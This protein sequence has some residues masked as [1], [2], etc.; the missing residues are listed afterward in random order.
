MPTIV[1]Q[2]VVESLEEALG[3]DDVRQILKRQISQERLDEL[4]K[5][6]TD[7]EKSNEI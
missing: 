2:C 4:V 7:K 3:N 5:K 1:S 6:Q